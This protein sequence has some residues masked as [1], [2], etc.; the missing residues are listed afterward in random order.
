MMLRDNV[1]NKA[2]AR[3][4]HYHNSRQ[5]QDLVCY[6]HLKRVCNR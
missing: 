6:L 4:T 5:P 2:K 1:V 3:K